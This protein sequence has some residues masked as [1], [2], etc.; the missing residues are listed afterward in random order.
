MLKKTQKKDQVVYI[1]LPDGRAGTVSADRQ[2]NIY[3]DFP[4]DVI[5]ADQASDSTHTK[6]KV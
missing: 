4:R 2:T 1:K 3:Y 5:I 6:V